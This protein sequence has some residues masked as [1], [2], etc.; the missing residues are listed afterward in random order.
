MLILVDP[1]S[2]VPVYRQIVDQIRFQVASGAARPGDELPSTRHLS[3][4]LGVNPMTVS[5]AYGLLEAEGV[6]ER[7]PGRPLVVAERDAD[8]RRAERIQRLRDELQSAAT[9]IRQLGVDPET[10]VAELRRLLDGDPE[11][12]DSA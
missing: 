8:T 11:R 5:K 12:S 10:A 9:R 7:R 3:A 2:G 1:H 6:L 4:E